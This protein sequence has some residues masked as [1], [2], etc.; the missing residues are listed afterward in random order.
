MR[1]KCEF[2]GYQ[3]RLNDAQNIILDVGKDNKDITILYVRCYEC[4][5]EWVE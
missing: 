5:A 2:C 4:G 3:P 1:L